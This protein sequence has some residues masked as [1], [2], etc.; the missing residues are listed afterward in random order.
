MTDNELIAFL[1]STIKG[2]LTAVGLSSTLPIKQAFQ[3]TQQGIVSAPAVYLFKIGD[4]RYGSPQRLD[5]WNAQAQRMDHTE[6]QIYETM[7]Q[8]SAR[9]EQ[10]PENITLPTSSDIANLISI[11][12]QSD[13]TLTAFRDAG[14]GLE[15]ITEVRNPY[16]TDDRD[17]HQA[18]PNFDFVI[19]HKRVVT[20]TTPVVESVEFQVL[21]V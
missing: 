2:Q 18:M 21:P 11:I 12:L 9:A 5:V 20:T 15:R 8:I 14:I 7:F 10:D 19:I 3:P 16:I 1:I 6:S 13:A 17:R 4:H